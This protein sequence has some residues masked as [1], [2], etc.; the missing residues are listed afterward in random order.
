MNITL[1]KQ[2]SIRKYFIENSPE[3]WEVKKLKSDICEVISDIIV[4]SLSPEE[5]WIMENLNED[6][7]LY[8]TI[9]DF[10]IS[11]YRDYDY[12]NIFGFKFP[13]QKMGYNW[14]NNYS[15]VEV[16]N[17]LDC[18][19]INKLPHIIINDWSSLQKL[20]PT[21][22]E[23]IQN[24]LKKSVELLDILEDKIRQLD[25]LLNS[26]IDLRSVNKYFPELYKIIKK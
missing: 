13:N 26:N 2:K 21:K 14:N 7:D 12:D 4:S 23:R 22:F 9:S 11:P 8:T 3:Y 24:L 18:Y 19:E 20:D 5:K 25:I 6:K 17:I 10:I 16:Y 15:L 1:T